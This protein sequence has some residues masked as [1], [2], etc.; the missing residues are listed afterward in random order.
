MNVITHMQICTRKQIFAVWMGL[1]V[2]TRLAQLVSSVCMVSGRSRVRIPSRLYFHLRI[3][4]RTIN[5]MHLYH[6]LIYNVF[7]LI[8]ILFF[9]LTTPVG[10][11]SLPQSLCNRSFWWRLWVVTLL[12]GFFCWYRGFCYRTES[13]LFLFSFYIILQLIYSIDSGKSINEVLFN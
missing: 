13:D 5:W 12:F 10:W 3:T 8:F 9:Y 11:Y 6:R 2:S 4:E 1:K 7:I